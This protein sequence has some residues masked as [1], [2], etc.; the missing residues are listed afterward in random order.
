MFGVVGRLAVTKDVYTPNRKVR[1]MKETRETKN[2]QFHMRLSNTELEMW[3]QAAKELGYTT[4][5]DMA[6][7][8]ITSLRV[9]NELQKKIREDAA[10]AKVAV[11]EQLERIA[12]MNDDDR[13]Y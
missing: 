7:D 2:T 3:K 8:A 12:S 10:L 6:R 1:H 4:L 9:N 5:S 11:V 13:D